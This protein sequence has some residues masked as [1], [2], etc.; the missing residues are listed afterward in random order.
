MSLRAKSQRLND[1]TGRKFTK[2]LGYKIT[3]MKAIA[4]F[5]TLKVI[6][7][8]IILA[9]C[10]G[11]NNPHHV[12][13]QF[14]ENDI[15]GNYTAMYQLL[16]DS[17][18]QAYSLNEFVEYKQSEE[19]EIDILSQHTSFEIKDV[20]VNEDKA[21]AMVDYRLPDIE[22]IMGE[23]MIRMF[24]G[25]DFDTSRI[26]QELTEKMDEGS[27]SYKTETTS[28]LLV[29]EQGGWKV[30]QGLAI[31]KL[32]SEA[33]DLFEKSDFDQAKTLYEQIIDQANFE[34]NNESL[35]I[36]EGKLKAIN[37]I[38]NI[39]LYD[40]ESGYIE[41]FGG[42]RSAGIRF[43]VRNNSDLD[44]S[45]VQVRVYYMDSDGNK[46]HDKSFTPVMVTEFS[47]GNNEPLRAGYIFQMPERQ[48]YTSDSV[49]NEWEE[50]NV[51][52]SVIDIE[53]M[54]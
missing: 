16:S 23:F 6:I 31:Q 9:G 12:L 30:E 41:T 28:Y 11:D 50:G 17:D 36:A 20:E 54:D 42:D 8:I 26:E 40:I 35:N 14:I 43:K 21:L 48:Y 18:K 49:P 34:V 2:H 13:N 39:D 51:S 33:D 1:T 3:H 29:K 24:S 44:L 52:V 32:L 38:D 15:S 5:A 4:T 25:A 22:A 47:F 10:N 7:L 45:K 19:P 37:V 27:V 46:I 53:I